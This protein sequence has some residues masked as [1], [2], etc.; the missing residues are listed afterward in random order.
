LFVIV[1]TEK[2]NQMASVYVVDENGELY[3]DMYAS[4]TAAVDAVLEKT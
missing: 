1:F 3:P 4:Y 2:P